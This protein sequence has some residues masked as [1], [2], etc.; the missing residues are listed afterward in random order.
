MAGFSSLHSDSLWSSSG[1][2]PK[3]SLQK[4]RSLLEVSTFRATLSIEWR[5]KTHSEGLVRVWKP[6]ITW[7][8]PTMLQYLQMMTYLLKKKVQQVQVFAC[9]PASLQYHVVPVEAVVKLGSAALSYLILQTAPLN[10]PHR[11]SNVLVVGVQ[12]DAGVV[13][14]EQ[15]LDV[16]P[17]PQVGGEAGAVLPG[18][19]AQ[20]VE[21]ARHGL[22]QPEDHRAD[23]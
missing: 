16:A 19:V 7:K 20:E 9:Q 17:A 21:S 1:L 4:E 10:E 15:A 2:F 8:L 14:D 5:G 23:G 11:R 18:Q 12:E 22:E 3:K 6:P 13:E